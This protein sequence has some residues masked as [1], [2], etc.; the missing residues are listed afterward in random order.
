[1]YRVAPGYGHYDSWHD[2]IVGDRMVAMSVNLS[3]EIYSGGLLQIREKQS[4]RIV[5]EVANVGFGDGVVFRLDDSLQHR[6]T[7]IKGEVPKTAFA[8]W[9]QSRPDFL[10]LLAENS[11]LA[12]NSRTGLR[13]GRNHA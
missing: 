4:K 5:Q 2:D 12:A 13:E 1:V 9:F 7:D 3:T 10:T 11:T 8:G 6:I